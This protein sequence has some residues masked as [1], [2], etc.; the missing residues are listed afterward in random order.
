MKELDPRAE[1]LVREAAHAEAEMVL[2]RAQR[3]EIRRRFAAH[4]LTQVRLARP[5]APSRA[6]ASIGGASAFGVPVWAAAA[7]GLVVSVAGAVAVVTAR[8]HDTRVRD[9]AD[10]RPA[11]ESQSPMPFRSPAPGSPEATSPNVASVAVE[12][13]PQAAR[14]VL[15]TAASSARSEVPAASSSASHVSAASAAGSHHPEGGLGAEAALLEAAERS[16]RA[17]DGARALALLDEYARRFP[18]G[19]L[20]VDAEAA[21]A[22]AT[23]ET[24]DRVGGAK[25]AADFARRWPNAP[26]LAR[27]LVACRTPQTEP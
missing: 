6:V 19:V 3:D 16:L 14:P 18:D 26:V 23:C 21:R 15:V 12:P 8:N 22:I 17:H 2:S 11:L 4:Q 27:V 10:A 25:L 20:F 5:S 1:A 13:S 9:S 7:V 24:A